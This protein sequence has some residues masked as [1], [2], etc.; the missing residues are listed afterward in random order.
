MIV[1][2]RTTILIF[3]ILSYGP[4]FWQI[5]YI[6]ADETINPHWTNTGCIECHTSEQ[7]R[8]LRY[9]GDDVLLCTRCHDGTRASREPHP[10]EF[11]FSNGTVSS[12]SL[13][14]PVRE[15]CIT[16]LTCHDAKPQMS[17]NLLMKLV[18][19]SF[20]RGD[21]QESRTDFCFTCHPQDLYQKKNPH[22]QTDQEGNMIETLCLLCH[23]T[24]PRPEQV[25]N[26]T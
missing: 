12:H 16:C 4:A 2:T 20:L 15:G 5:K 13:N 11:A 8:T 3:T 23:R 24:V 25:T 10:V 21:P 17:E 9:A 14:W 26:S 22:Q 7:G 1:S 18:N 19:P 6:C